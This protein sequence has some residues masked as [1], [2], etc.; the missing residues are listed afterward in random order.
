[1]ATSLAR[2]LAQQAAR[3]ASQFKGTASLLYSSQEAAHIDSERIFLDACAGLDELCHLDKRF[4][5]FKGS[6]FSDAARKLERDLLG[7]EE[8]KKLASTIRS[9]LQLLTPHVL[10][11]PAHLALEF[12]IRR[13]Q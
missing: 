3:P 7:P 1:M 9:F 13:F 6:L 12:L 11:P 2:Q 4:Y 10:L 5:E 8:A